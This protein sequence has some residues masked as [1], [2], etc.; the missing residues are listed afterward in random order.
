MDIGRSLSDSPPN[1]WTDHRGPRASALPII[2]H[3]PKMTLRKIGESEKHE[4]STRLESP[5]QSTAVL[6]MDYASILSAVDL[7]NQ[8]KSEP[9]AAVIPIFAHAA[10]SEAAFLNFI[11]ELVREEM[12]PLSRQ[13]YRI[14]A[15]ENLQYLEGILDRHVAQL[16][17]CI[18]GI[19]MLAGRSQ[20]QP[21]RNRSHLSGLG[22]SSDQ[23]E[24]TAF[25]GTTGT[26][27]AQGIL[28][29]YE[30]LLE[31]C[32]HLRNLCATAMDVDMNKT[33][34]AEARKAMEQTERMKKLSLLATYFIPLTFT[35]SLFGMNFDILGQGK[36]PVWWY[37][38][39]ALPLTVMTH[40]LNS[41]D[42]KT[43][44]TNLSSW[45]RDRW[46]KR[47]P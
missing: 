43:L 32:T 7:A 23:A 36:Q 8:A 5:F 20:Y 41:C 3:H 25:P 6:P 40:F 29:D 18:K 21:S 22:E 30:Y 37:F 39:F 2:Q 47:A 34:I 1:P 28:Q 35:A 13:Q 33:M 42:M 31:T 24:R 17:S 11:R 9:L 4:R 44:M 26:F 14:A 45:A 38:V 16:N 46:K 15:F 27:S 19:N 12:N 10:F